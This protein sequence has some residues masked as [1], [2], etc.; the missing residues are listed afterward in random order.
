MLETIMKH[1]LPLMALAAGGLLYALVPWLTIS[2]RSRVEGLGQE[3]VL[4][5]VLCAF[6][7]LQVADVL[8]HEALDSYY[9]RL[10]LRSSLSILAVLVVLVVFNASTRVFDAKFGKTRRIDGDEVAVAS[11]HSRM[12]SG[13]FLILLV[14]L[15]TY[16]LIEIW[17][18]ESLL[19]RTGFIGIIA[20]FFVLT[21]SAWLPDLFYGLVL[22]N[23]SMTEEG[24]TIRLPE[25]DDI[26][27]VNRLTP[28]Y[29][30]LLDV[31]S[32]HR[33][34]IRNSALIRS[35]IENLS[36]RAS[37]DGIRRQLELKI[38]Y[39]A[40]ASGAAGA[41]GLLAQVD[42]M[43]AATAERAAGDPD[44][45]VNDKEPFKWSLIEAGDDA[46][47]FA[48]YYHLAPLPDTKLTGKIR[49]HLQLSAHGMTR[50]IFEEA[51]ARGLNLATPS[52][53][54]LE[55]IGEEGL[56]RAAGPV[57]HSAAPG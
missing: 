26:Y 57:S 51:S 34:L 54:S 56:M 39:P 35:R 14:A 20:A 42:A 27:I 29:A 8:L 4:W 43:V 44:L 53:V 46:L 18:L 15:L 49:A 24:D 1:W 21:S 17:G 36:K 5:V 11:Y 47:R 25:Q 33:V 28:F 38:G 45:H 12:A 32:N 6:V 41:N 2:G 50:L 13:L 10:L 23:S 3:V 30:I 16:V 9:N 37:I 19:E 22:L 40:I 55:P 31:N 48:I 52:L 7:V